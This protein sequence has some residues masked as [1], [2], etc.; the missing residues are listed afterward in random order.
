MYIGFVWLQFA[1]YALSTS[2]IG[3]DKVTASFIAAVNLSFYRY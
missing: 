3:I 1:V 2:I